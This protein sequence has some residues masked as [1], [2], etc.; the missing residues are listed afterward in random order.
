VLQ[1]LP[2]LDVAGHFFTAASLE[3]RQ[4]DREWDAVAAFAGVAR[5]DLR[6]LHQVHGRRIAVSRSVGGQVWV[7]PEADG[8][9][10]DE[11]TAAFGVRIADCAPVLIADRRRGAVA[12][13]HAGWRSTMQRICSAAVEAMQRELDSSPR[14]LV[15]AIGPCLGPCCGEMGEEVVQAFRD[16][17]HDEATIAG[18]FSREPGRKPHFD[19]W[20]ANVDQLESSGVPREAIHVSGLCTRSHPDVFHSY[21][22]QGPGAGRM[23]GVIRASVDP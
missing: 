4:D 13:V 11:R 8:V 10:S 3:L 9:V 15:V 1:C 12:A 16:A 2:L 22:D 23:V 7:P 19:L 18:W 14:D 21:R 5:K 17:G 20:R 6:L